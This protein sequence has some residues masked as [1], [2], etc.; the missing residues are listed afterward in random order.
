MVYMGHVYSIDATQMELLTLDQGLK[1]AI[2]HNLVTFEINT[3]CLAIL[4]LTKM[5]DSKYKNIVANCRH[6][7]Q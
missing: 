6:I 2:Q 1:I 7:L 4:S 3:D 5:L